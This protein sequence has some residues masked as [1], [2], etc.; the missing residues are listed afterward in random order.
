MGVAKVAGG[1]LGDLVDEGLDFAAAVN[2]KVTPTG[3]T[4]R[5]LTGSLTGATQD[6]RRVI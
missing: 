4:T 2:D 5:D 3:S 6:T 1:H